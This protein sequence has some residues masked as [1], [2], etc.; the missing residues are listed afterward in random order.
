MDQQPARAMHF[1]HPTMLGLCCNTAGYPAR[2]LCPSPPDAWRPTKVS[3]T[4][5]PSTIG[6]RSCRVNSQLPCASQRDR[7]NEEEDAPS[8]RHAVSDAHAAR[9]GHGPLSPQ[10]CGLA[11]LQH[12]SPSH[13]HANTMTT[14]AAPLVTKHGTSSRHE[15]P[16]VEVFRARQSRCATNTNLL[17]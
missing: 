10:E 17:L 8:S 16:G 12:S 2:M 1:E 6:D 11:R 7:L 15:T 13:H 4:S 5:R 14:S 3:T 9:S